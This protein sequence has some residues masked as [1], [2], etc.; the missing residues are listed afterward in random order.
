[1]SKTTVIFRKELHRNLVVL[2][3]YMEKNDQLNGIAKQ[4]NATYS[5]TKKMWWL[6][7]S[8]QSVNKAFE[9]FQSI[10]WVDYSALK[11]EKREKDKADKPDIGSFSEA[12]RHA[13]MKYQETMELRRMSQNTLNTYVSFF[14]LFVAAHPTD[15]PAAIDEDRIKQFVLRIVK[16]RDY[17]YKTQGQLINAL[18][19]YYEQVLGMNKQEYWLPRPRKQTTLPTVISKEE[20][21]S[22]LRQPRYTKHKL[23]L[24]LVY[25]AGL[26]SGELLNLR[27]GDLNTERMMIHIR[28]GKG[29]KDRY[30][31]LPQGL[32]PLIN[33]YLKEHKPHYWLIEGPNQKKYSA[34][35]VRHVF[36]RACED[37]GIDKKL[38][39]HDLRHSFATH[40][41]ESGTNLRNI[42]ELLGH[43][44][45]E[46][47]AIY[48]HVTE[49]SLRNVKSPLDI[50][51]DSNKLNNN[52]LNK[53]NP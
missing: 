47:T 19:F 31:V 37:A 41:L 17:A 26:R 12:Q 18:K 34:S 50:I 11:T 42:Q 32:L 43:S 46:T 45:A 40:L 4:L 35:S 38:R 16:E 29:K 13:L 8:K 25:G 44:S 10:A 22:I 39:L 52:N 33:K 28:G 30:T 36:H 51:I 7:F 20:V 3:M 23:C 9:A 21:M 2:S 27:K 1:M 48:T 53:T 5:N 15:D 14:K 6:A 49:K 24:A